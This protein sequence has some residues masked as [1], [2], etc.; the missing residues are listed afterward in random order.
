MRTHPKSAGL[1]NSAPHF[2][3]TDPARFATAP[4]LEILSFLGGDFRIATQ[5][6]N[7]DFRI[8]TASLVQGFRT[9]D[10]LPRVCNP[11]ALPTR[12]DF[13]AS[14]EDAARL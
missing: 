9:L 12:S 3:V 2:L 1:T 8:P 4:G 6:P 5:A 13:C 11:Q 7:R 14:A 10:Q